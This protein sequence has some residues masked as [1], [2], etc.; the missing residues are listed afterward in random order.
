MTAVAWTVALLAAI[1]VL[2][3]PGNPAV[4][5]PRRAP[6]HLRHPH[7]RP[8]GGHAVGIQ[9]RLLQP[10]P[11]QRAVAGVVAW[12]HGDKEVGQALVVDTCLFMVLGSLALFASD[13]MALSRPRGTGVGGALAEGVPPHL[14]DEPPVPVGSD[15]AAIAQNGSEPKTAI[16]SFEKSRASSR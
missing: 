15:V 2:V 3:F 8:C 9:R 7:L 10:L 13:R 14:P 16:V 6:G 12:A 11:R 4:L 1:H 5:P